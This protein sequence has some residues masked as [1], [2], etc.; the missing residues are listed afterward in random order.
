MKEI[1]KTTLFTVGVSA[2]A[3]LSAYL[4][5]SKA[6][7]SVNKCSYLDPVIIDVLAFGAAIF[8]IVEGVWRI[9]EYHEE[10]W[11]KQV[12]RAFRVAF[13]CAILTL[14]IMQFLHK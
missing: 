6:S 11:Q 5:Q 14:H 2:F 13:G 8:L 4:I 9:Y 1:A 7:A 10:P 3:S 12:T